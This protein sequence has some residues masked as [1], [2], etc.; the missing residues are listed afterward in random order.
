MQRPCHPPR[1]QGAAAAGRRSA[2]DRSHRVPGRRRAAADAHPSGA[3]R[4]GSL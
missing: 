3:Q 1:S 4:M 2:G